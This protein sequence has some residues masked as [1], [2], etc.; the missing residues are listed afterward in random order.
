MKVT[1][2]LDLE[3]PKDQ[4]TYKRFFSNDGTITDAEIVQDST[5]KKKPSKRPAKET[6]ELPA[7]DQLKIETVRAE[8]AKKVGEH[9]EAIKAKLTELGTPNLTNLDPGKY[10]EYIDYLKAL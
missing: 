8:Q 4:H 6:P 3:N 1:I 7:K 10:Q 5:S 2:E 9:R